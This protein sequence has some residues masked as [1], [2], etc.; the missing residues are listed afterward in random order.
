MTETETR[1]RE[2]ESD[3]VVES[4]DVVAEDVVAVTLV[5]PRGEALPAWTPEMGSKRPE[6][7]LACEREANP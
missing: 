4:Y 2:F 7:P 1:L 6:G 5:H 3:L